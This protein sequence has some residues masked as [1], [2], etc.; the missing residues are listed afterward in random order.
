MA[1]R[2]DDLPLDVQQALADAE[3][4][5]AA[6]LSRNIHSVGF[7]KRTL[8]GQ[9]DLRGHG[10]I[11]TVAI[12][13]DRDCIQSMSIPR[14]LGDGM[15][16]TDVIQAPPAEIELLRESDFLTRFMRDPGGQNRNCHN[17]PIP[18][19]V[20]IQP[21]GQR[22]V[23]TLGCKVVRIAKDGSLR[24]GAITNWHVATGEVGQRMVQH[25]GSSEWFGEVASSPGIVFGG[26]NYVDLAVLDIQR[27][28]GP[29]AP[30]THTVKPEQLT[31]GSYSKEISEGGVGTV[32]ARD[33]RT[34]GRIIDGRCSQIGATVRVGY[35]GGKVALF[36]DQF[37][38]TRQGGE[39][40]AS[41]DS[42][43]MVFEYPAMR[44]F[45]LLFAGGTGTTIVSPAEYGI[46]LGRVHSFQ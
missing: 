34:L 23:G 45:G 3:K 10:V 8:D 5:M 37:V 36:K 4:M 12:K 24:H 2:R 32:V 15:V 19:G 22:W 17:T 20:E 1:R 16:S 39:F 27:T 44:P 18:G 28:D 40:S 7:G 43:S 35:G 31:L 46:E 25:G 33:G 38:C 9:P 41:G 29:Y 21:T 30:I 6:D 26:T 13:G 14:T 11:F 42:G